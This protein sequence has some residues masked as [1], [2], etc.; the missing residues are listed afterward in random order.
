MRIDPSV[1]LHQSLGDAQ[2]VRSKGFDGLTKLELTGTD[3]V[4]LTMAE[5]HHSS[6]SVTS[7]PLMK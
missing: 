6:M 1:P 3:R 4:G 5:L 7:I 2:F